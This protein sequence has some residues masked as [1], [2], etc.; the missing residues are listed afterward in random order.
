MESLRLLNAESDALA[1]KSN[2]Y[3]MLDGN[4]V[5]VEVKVL[6]DAAELVSKLEE[7]FVLVNSVSRTSPSLEVW[8]AVL[9][10]WFIEACAPEA[11]QTNLR[12]RC[13]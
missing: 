7:L 10:K 2:A 3:R 8:S 9:P 13:L 4:F 1:G 6:G 11:T 5:D 12:K